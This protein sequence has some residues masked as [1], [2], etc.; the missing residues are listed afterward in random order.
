M[1]ASRWV[2]PSWLGR[3]FVTTCLQR[4]VSLSARR[5]VNNSWTAVSQKNMR[6]RSC[7][8]CHTRMGRYTMLP[9]RKSGKRSRCAALWR[10]FL[11]PSE[12][13]REPFAWGSVIGP[14]KP[15]SQRRIRP[16][17]AESS[18]Y[19]TRPSG[20]CD[21][22]CRCSS[23]PV[24]TPLSAPVPLASTL[25]CH[26]AESHNFSPPPSP[27]IAVSATFSF[28]E[29]GGCASGERDGEYSECALSA[30]FR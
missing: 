19:V 15:S 6:T 25:P 18:P 26:I 28:G 27:A 17:P 9:R 22:A 12:V 30:L 7:A 23:V 29:L 10:P 20:G 21:F 16:C 11:A 1:H 8:S 5:S 2:A 4:T 13:H 24:A 3:S 14:L